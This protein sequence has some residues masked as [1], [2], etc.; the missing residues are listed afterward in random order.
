MSSAKV[1]VSNEGDFSD[2]TDSL[3][4][5]DEDYRENQS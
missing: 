3:E 5:G 4:L 1:K 2:R